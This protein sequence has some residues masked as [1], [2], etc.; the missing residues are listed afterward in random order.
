MYTAAP[1]KTEILLVWKTEEW[2]LDRQLAVWSM[3][4]F[5]YLVDLGFD[6]LQSDKFW[7]IQSSL[8]FSWIT[9]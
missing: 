7:L 5:A 6:H 9:V 2:I 3:F 8:S 1:Y 4:L